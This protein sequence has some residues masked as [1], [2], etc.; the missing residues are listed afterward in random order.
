MI[1][2]LD[3]PEDENRVDWIEQYVIKITFAINSD[4]D[5]MFEI[6][7]MDESEEHLMITDGPSLRAAIDRAILS[8][9]A[10]QS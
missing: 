9:H 3:Q 5:P 7:Y 2:K 6:V 8:V 4:G 10:Q 1:P